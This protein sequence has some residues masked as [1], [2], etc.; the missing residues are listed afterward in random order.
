MSHIEALIADDRYVN[1]NEKKP[2]KA[3][4]I[5]PLFMGAIGYGTYLYLNGQDQSHSA[6]FES[7]SLSRAQLSDV[8]EQ[9]TDD[10]IMLADLGNM[11]GIT[12]MQGGINVFNGDSFGS[13]PPLNAWEFTYSAGRR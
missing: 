12:K 8:M 10:S 5:I 13:L 7:E 3:K 9:S 1:I 2:S 4:W 11:P 6:D